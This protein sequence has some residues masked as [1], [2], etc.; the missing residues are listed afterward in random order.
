MGLPLFI[1]PVEPEVSSKA[2]EKIASGP[3]SSIRR[4]RTLRGPHAR[5]TSEARRRRILGMMPEAEPEEFEV[6][7]GQQAN[8]SDLPSSV[9]VA[10]RVWRD[11]LSFERQ[12][13]PN[14]DIDGPLMPPVPESRDYSF[15]EERQREIHRLRQVR[16]DLR[17]MA[18]RHPAPTPPYTDSDLAFLARTDSP[19][20]SSSMTPV[21]SPSRHTSTGDSFSPPRRSFEDAE[22]SFT[23]VRGPFTDS[24]GRSSASLSERV[25]SLNQTASNIERS[26]RLIRQ[27]RLD[28]LGD[29]DRS[30]SPEGGAAWDT[31]LTSITPDPQPPSVGSSFAST[32]AAAA[33]TSSSASGPSSG[34][35]SAS[36]STSMTSPD[37]V[38]DHECD[39][40]D[41]ESNTEDEE[42]DIYELQEFNGS[43]RGDRFWRTYADVVTTR[44]DRA[45]RQDTD[46]GGMHRIISRLARRDEIPDNWWT[47]AGL[48][49]NL[50]REPTN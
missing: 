1:T 33:A 28:G 46:L 20:L 50:R 12:H 23:S 4:Q 35:A 47:S 36:A 7:E 3:R 30:M 49:R 27:A 18:R 32:S 15:A 19:R 25:R 17:R 37:R 24:M 2:A 34:S 21:L 5:L 10:S 40:S 26:R 6:S 48:S 42:E 11:A 44:A 45:G 14:S 9:P 39:I 29:R 22:F 31:L 38:G 16:Q 13:P 41:S 43:R 8:I